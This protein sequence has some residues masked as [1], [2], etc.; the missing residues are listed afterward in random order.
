M[1]IMFTSKDR[2]HIYFE[3]LYKSYNI[4]GVGQLNNIGNTFTASNIYSSEVWE[5]SIK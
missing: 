1:K 2:S 3:I 5:Q 4:H